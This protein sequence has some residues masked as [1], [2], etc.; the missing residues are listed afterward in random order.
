MYISQD[1]I[2]LEAG[3]RNLYAYVLDANGWWID[4]FGLDMIPNK[5]AGNAREE[6]A[7]ISIRRKHPKVTILKERYIRDVTGKS[8][9][10]PVSM[11]RRRLDFA[12]VENGRLTSNKSYRQ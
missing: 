8:V 2:R 3:L 10:D 1:P 6:L 12:V 5:V 4:P 9:F 11:S 7:G